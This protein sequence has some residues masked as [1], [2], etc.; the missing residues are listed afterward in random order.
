MKCA[1]IATE[2]RGHA[3]FRSLKED[4]LLELCAMFHEKRFA[5]G[6]FLIKEGQKNSSLFFLRNGT[7]EVTQKNVVIYVGSEPGEVLEK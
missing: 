3:F 2:I 1:K 4:L 5:S 6:E 7:A